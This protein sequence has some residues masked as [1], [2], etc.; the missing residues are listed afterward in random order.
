VAC[1]A[2]P[3]ADK[4]GA[5]ALCPSAFGLP[6]AS[7][8]SLIC[9]RLV[10]E[11]TPWVT[12]CQAPGSACPSVAQYEAAT[13]LSASAGATSRTAALSGRNERSSP[14]ERCSA[15]TARM[16]GA[17]SAERAKR[18]LLTCRYATSA[19]GSSPSC[20]QR[21]T[22]AVASGNSVG[23]RPDWRTPPSV[24]PDAILANVSCSTSVSVAPARQLVDRGRAADSAADHHD[25]VKLHHESGSSF[26]LLKIHHLTET[27]LLS[28]EPTISLGESDKKRGHDPSPSPRRGRKTP[29]GRLD[30]PGTLWEAV[31][32]WV[33]GNGAVITRIPDEYAAAC[34]IA[35][36][37]GDR[38]K[39]LL[40]RAL[41]A[42]AD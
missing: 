37:F 5:C 26:T 22:A 21:A 35:I 7:E 25:V 29:L 13:T 23:S 14:S 20:S 33:R 3:N 34:F 24:H 16:I 41:L 19:P 42:I 32:A 1:L 40:S 38:C 15:T 17:S 30:G 9:V 39:W 4:L 18:R 31:G 2:K 12:A 28:S 8:V 36:L 10:G 11:R 27:V 6:S